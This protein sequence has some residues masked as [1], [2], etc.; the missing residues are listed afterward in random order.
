M[1]IFTIFYCLKLLWKEVGEVERR[2]EEEGEGLM[3]Y[4]LDLVLYQRDLGKS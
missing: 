2:K 1:K 4:V 3:D